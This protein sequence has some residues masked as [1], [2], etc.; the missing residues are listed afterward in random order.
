MSYGK[1]ERRQKHRIEAA[2]ALEIFYAASKLE[3]TSKNISM[4]GTYLENEQEIKTGTDVEII[5]HIPAYGHYRKPIGAIKC[6][7]VIFRSAP[8]IKPN[9]PAIFAL[10]IFFISFDSKGDS[11]KLSDYIDYM[12]S[13]E[14]TFVKKR[15]KQ[16]RSKLKRERAKQKRAEK[17]ALRKIKKDRT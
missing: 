12:V 5:I 1:M 2:L 14:K 13:K 10:G 7:G 4:L 16:L 11:D 17:E 9:S 8:L 15:L 6:H 3:A